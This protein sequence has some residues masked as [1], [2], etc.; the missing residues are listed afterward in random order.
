MS[1]SQVF[2]PDVVEWLMRYGLFCVVTAF[3]LFVFALLMRPFWLWFSGKSEVRDR[4][5]HLE[6]TS[7]KTLLELE[8]LNQTL[9]IPIKKAAQKA[10]NT[11][12]E[13]EPLVVSQETKDA[14]MKVLSKRPPS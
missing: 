4:L 11:E 2:P 7:R 14:F 5:K 3:S 6:E 9:T 10:R 13:E 12:K 1:M 8:I